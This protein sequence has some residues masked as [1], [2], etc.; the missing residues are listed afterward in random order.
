[1]TLAILMGLALASAAAPVDRPAVH[2]AAIPHAQGSASAVYHAR[3]KVEAHDVIVRPGTTL[4]R[5]QAE[6]GLVR[7]VSR[8]DGAPV[9]A[10]SRSVGATRE[11]GGVEQTRCSE[12][13]ARIAS[14]VD[15]HVRHR[16]DAMAAAAKDDH[17][18]LLSELGAAKTSPI[19]S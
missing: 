16:S 4:C 15:N 10:L 14:A 2:S 5:W 6:V 1:M 13:R 17:A 18:L 12:A 7:E 19:G 8:T 9:T 3:S 11:I